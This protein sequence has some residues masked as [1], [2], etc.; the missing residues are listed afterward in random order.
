M[1]NKFL[2]IFPIVLLVYSCENGFDKSLISKT[3]K[4]ISPNGGYA[5]YRYHIES[6]M[7]FGSGFTVINILKSD[8]KCDVTDRNILRFGNNSPFWIKWKNDKTLIV[9]CLIDGGKL[10]AHQPIKTEVVKWKDWTFNVEYYSM[11][12]SGLESDFIFD[13][14]SI[15]GNKIKF[16]SNLN[17]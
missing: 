8:E 9:K 1:K 4:L 11:Y 14:Y 5:L 7:A 12:S 16:K 10:A 13:S 2:F 6:P 17:S 15:S 3:E